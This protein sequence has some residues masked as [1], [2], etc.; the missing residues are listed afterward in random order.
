MLDFCRGQGVKLLLFAAAAA[1]LSY[2][3]G[4]EGL[5][6][7]RSSSFRAKV[8]AMFSCIYNAAGPD[9]NKLTVET[10]PSQQG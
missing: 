9:L 3:Y 7:Q 8:K 1:Q 4:R 10:A 2:L 5:A 6:T